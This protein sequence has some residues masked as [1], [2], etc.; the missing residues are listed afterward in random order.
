MEGLQ[1]QENWT[2][3]FGVQ[4]RV[5]KILQSLGIVEQAMHRVEVTHKMEDQTKAEIEAM[6]ELE[7]KK[8]R[9]QEEMDRSHRIT[10]EPVP[11]LQFEKDV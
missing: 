9:R 10:V 5:V 3:Y 1:A 8:Q 2:G 6:V 7:R 4:E 11:Q